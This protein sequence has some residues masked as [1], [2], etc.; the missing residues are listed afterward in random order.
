MRLKAFYTQ[1][2]SAYMKQRDQEQLQRRL[3]HDLLNEIQVIK[4]MENKET[5]DLKGA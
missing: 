2:M 1:E 4:Y 5:D 3:R